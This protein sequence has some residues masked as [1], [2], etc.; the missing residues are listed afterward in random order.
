M[1]WTRKGC[2]QPL[3]KGHM[4]LSSPPRP[5]TCQPHSSGPLNEA[6]TGRQARVPTDNFPH[7]S[8]HEQRGGRNEG[9]KER[10]KG[11]GQN[12]DGV[13]RKGPALSHS[14]SRRGE[15][16]VRYL[17]PA[18][19]LVLALALALGR[20]GKAQTDWTDGTL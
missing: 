10:R 9:T 11:K 16:G 15:E 7:T 13:G 17:L 8:E 6:G 5:Q 1:T 4:D 2:R 18:V 3:W 19:M 14:L 20:E 12:V